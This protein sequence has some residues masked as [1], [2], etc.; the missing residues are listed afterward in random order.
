M[1]LL[2]S[3]L[4]Y[5][6]LRKEKKEKIELPNNEDTRLLPSLRL[7]VPNPNIYSPN[8]QGNPIPSD[9]SQ[10]FR[11]SSVRLRNVFIDENW[12]RIQSIDI[13]GPST[14]FKRTLLWNITV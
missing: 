8:I 11:I 14:L 2:F 13:G 1:E 5:C 4:K 6:V 12:S 7:L 3:L 10:A 9:C